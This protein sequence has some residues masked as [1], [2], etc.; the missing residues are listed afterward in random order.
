MH[1]RRVARHSNQTTWPVTVKRIGLVKNLMG[2][3]I[4]STAFRPVGHPYG[5]SK[6]VFYIYRQIPIPTGDTV[7]SS[8]AGNRLVTLT[9]IAGNAN[10]VTNIGLPTHSVSTPAIPW[11]HSHLSRH[12]LPLSDHAD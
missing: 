8:C 4:I 11:M 1:A 5:I 10:P 7:C 2:K 9:L 3:V 6:L 12:R